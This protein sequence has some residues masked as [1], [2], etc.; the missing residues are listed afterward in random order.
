MPGE[1]FLRMLKMMIMPL[2]VSS[3]ISGKIMTDL[4]TK[5]DVIEMSWEMVYN[6]G[7]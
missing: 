6:P 7:G 3:V 1:L 4:S 2:I 5:F